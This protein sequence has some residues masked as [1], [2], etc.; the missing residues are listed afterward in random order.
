MTSFTFWLLITGWATKNLVRGSVIIRSFASKLLS[1][2]FCGVPGLKR[3][4]GSIAVVVFAA[5]FFISCGGGYGS[6][7]GKTTASGFGFRAFVSNP[8][9]P[10]RGSAFPVLNIVD[11][12]K[13]SYTGLPVS[14]SGTLTFPG[15]M[16]LSPNLKD[17][18][19]YSSTGNQIAVVDN[20]SEA[21]AQSSGN[22][23]AAIPLLGPTESMSIW[24][25][26]ATAFVAVPGAGVP[27]QSAGA[28]EVLGFL[29]GSTSPEAVIPI[30]SAHYLVQSHNG[31]SILV[32]S[33]N[34]QC[35][36]SQC[37]TM[38]SPTQI[39]TA[40]DPR[41]AIASPSFDHPVWGVFSNDDSTA[42]IFN[43]GPE[44]GGTTAS[45][46]ILD[47]TQIPPAVTSA[48]ILVPA[49]THGL[50]IGSTLYVAGTPS[51]TA[52]VACP[53][54]V[55]DTACGE[56]TTIDTGSLTASAPVTISEG[57]HDRMA[58]GA[59]G[60]LFIGASG[61]RGI[62]SSCLSIFNTTNSKVAFP[63]DTGVVTG[64]EPIT[65]RSVVYVCQ[66]GALKVYDTSTDQLE[67]VQIPIVGQ[68]IDVKLVDPPGNF[69]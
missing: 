14:L 59:N 36:G 53:S 46:S 34:A 54:G 18:L 3:A 19:V 60:Q 11:A 15:L 20:A 33:D 22:A 42:Y 62:C 45:I 47:L 10:F 16:A 64:I 27:G 8:L 29:S 26:S 63:T 57:Y 4:L 2:M 69:N 30:A 56:L 58:M 6:S 39:G 23:L 50:L 38:I 55:P 52:A 9:Q 12:A 13:D 44:C 66:N 5:V 68:A 49:A 43:C 67:S 21:L 35:G 31:N 37:I 48:P 17:T 32:F 24:I 28:V 51:G 25:D 40:A 1:F 61:S 7:S 41:T 65:D